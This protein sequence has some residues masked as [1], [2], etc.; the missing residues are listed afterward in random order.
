MNGV[1]HSSPSGCCVPGRQQCSRKHAT[2]CWVA[3]GTRRYTTLA[4]KPLFTIHEGEFLV[5]DYISRRYGSDYEVWIP[6]KDDGIDLLV[7][8][9]TRN[10]KPVRIQ[11]KHSR[12]FDA[13]H[14]LPDEYLG[15]ARGWY[16]LN[17]KK[18]RKSRADLWIFVILTLQHEK[19]FVIVP[20]KE[21][22]RRIPRDTKEK[23][24]MYLSVWGKD[25]CFNTRQMNK[26]ELLAA[27]DG[28]TV[29]LEQDYTEFLDNWDLIKR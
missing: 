12:G 18:I 25:C 14:A 4:M 6:A 11:V 26:G 10:A 3:V 22:I 8:H 13:R 20:T 1:P 15:C 23:W 2:R 28:G 5:G 21:L 17:P 29:T 19:H 27:L 7:T 16:T 24:H 9:K